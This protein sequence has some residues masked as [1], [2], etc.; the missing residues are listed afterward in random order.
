VD[1][2]AWG[3]CSSHPHAVR[4]LEKATMKKFELPKIGANCLALI[5]G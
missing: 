3:I 1:N 5:Q 2:I 4:V